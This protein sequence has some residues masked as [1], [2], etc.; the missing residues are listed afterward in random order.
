M[1]ARQEEF[2]VC[3]SHCSSVFKCNTIIIFALFEVIYSILQIHVLAT[4]IIISIVRV[5]SY[6]S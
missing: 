2:Y 3:N 5:I 6:S 4:V 1:T